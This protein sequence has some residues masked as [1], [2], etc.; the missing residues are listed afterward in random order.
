MTDGIISDPSK[1]HFD[2]EVLLCKASDSPN[3]LTQ[4]QVNSLKAYYGGGKDSQG[5]SIFP[6]LTMGD[7]AHGWPVSVVGQGP[8]SGDSLQYLQI[9]SATW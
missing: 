4:P 9:T 5:R 1:C 6:G 3:C 8:G 7:E 2:P